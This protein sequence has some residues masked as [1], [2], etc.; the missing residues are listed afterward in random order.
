MFLERFIQSSARTGPWATISL[1]CV[2]FRDAGS[3]ADIEW[4]AG[5][6]AGVPFVEVPANPGAAFLIF[7]YFDDLPSALSGPA[8]EP[9]PTFRVLAAFNYR[10]QPGQREHV[11]A[12][13]TAPRTGYQ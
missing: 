13:L 5:A 6:V 7:A 10:K 12:R 11:H 9:Q 3:P 2:H 8:K 1:G 4:L